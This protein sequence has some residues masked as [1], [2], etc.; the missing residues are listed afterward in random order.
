MVFPRG[1]EGR[2]LPNLPAKI[3]E[4]VS[5][6]ANAKEKG[7]ACFGDGGREGPG[8]GQ[9]IAVLGVSPTGTQSGCL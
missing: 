7:T 6:Q 8:T 3:F 1:T 4:V 5:N 9:R 2:A